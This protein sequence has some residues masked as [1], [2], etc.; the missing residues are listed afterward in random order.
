MTCLRGCVCYRGYGYVCT[1]R[2]H[3]DQALAFNQEG[4]TANMSYYDTTYLLQKL[5]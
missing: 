3:I 5:S 4:Y 2:V 1:F